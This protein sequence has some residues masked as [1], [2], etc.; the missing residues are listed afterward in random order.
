MFIVPAA[1][2]GGFFVWMSGGPQDVIV[3]ADRFLLRSMHTVVNL[4]SAAV[5]ALSKFMG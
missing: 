3:A 5:E 1:I 4:C 2:F